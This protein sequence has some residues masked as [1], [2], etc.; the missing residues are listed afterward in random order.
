MLEAKPTAGTVGSGRQGPG[1]QVGCDVGAG[2]QEA[3]HRSRTAEATV[4]VG[5]IL[6]SR[7][8]EAVSRV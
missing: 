3:P 8:S 2:G 6:G 7:R 1:I 4:A 5:I